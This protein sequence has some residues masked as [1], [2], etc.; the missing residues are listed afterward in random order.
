MLLLT[1]LILSTLTA[2][3]YRIGRGL[4]LFPPTV[5]CLFWTLDLILVWLAGNFFYPLSSESLVFFICGAFIFS[6]GAWLALVCPLNKLSSDSALP[7]SSNRP[8]SVL[9]ALIVVS[10][11]FCYYWIVGFSAGL[12][13]NLLLSARRALIEE[14]D[15]PDAATSLFN[16]I[17]G[18]SMMVALLAFHERAK[19]GKRS[20]LA[21]VASLALNLLSGGRSGI[22][23]LLI[24]LFCIDWIKTRRI[25][26]KPL[27]AIALTFVL[28]FGMMAVYLQKGDARTDAPI[29]ENAVPVLNG[30]V[31]YAAGG[32][33]AFD[34]VLRQPNIVPHNW[35]INRFFLQTMNK[36][37]GRFVVPALAA[38][39]VTVGPD[40]LLTN[41]YTFYFAYID[42]GPVGMMSV[43]S[44][45][46]FIITIFYRRAIGGSRVSTL[47]F[48]ALLGGLI[49]SVFNESL[50]FNLNFL[51]KLWLFSWLFYRLPDSLAVLSNL[52]RR[53]VTNG[54]KVNV[55]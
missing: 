55:A 54:P 16:N 53:S 46:S 28:A 52:V 29:A 27:A 24:G 15:E 4:L 26:W 50:L 7:K 14:M 5:F 36:I 2:V 45:I 38:D 25:R 44:F 49:L 34:R 17:V 33:V 8:L 21:I 12:G 32:L 20:F 48:S 22:V 1:I 37:G 47:L 51:L 11:P 40:Y 43:I 3:N 42:L 6:C 9:T 35:Q 18:L 19:G 23:A 41:V 31:L 13:S 30:F 39:Y 10:V